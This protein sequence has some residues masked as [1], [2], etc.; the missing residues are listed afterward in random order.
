MCR[1]CGGLADAVFVSAPPRD[2]GT[3]LQLPSAVSP[4]VYVNLLPSS[5]GDGRALLHGIAWSRGGG[6][7]PHSKNLGAR[8]EGG[9]VCQFRHPQ[10]L[11]S[12]PYDPLQLLP[13]HQRTHAQLHPSRSEGDQEDC[14]R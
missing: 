1:A 2:E 11:I 3:R 14:H 6:L 7:N 12:L 8:L 4:F 5:R 10:T 13:L 9:R